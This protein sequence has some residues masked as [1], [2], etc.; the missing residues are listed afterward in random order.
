[1]LHWIN[2]P[3]ARGFGWGCFA[4]H[5]QCGSLQGAV[6]VNDKCH[7]CALLDG[8][9]GTRR[10][11]PF[12]V[13]VALSLLLCLSHVWWQ[14]YNGGAVIAMKGRNSVAIA[15]DMRSVSDAATQTCLSLL[16]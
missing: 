7:S 5:R 6:C 3:P 2:R 8:R 9:H 4:N 11:A 1:M 16:C 15:T 13:A 10:A 12:G 14:E